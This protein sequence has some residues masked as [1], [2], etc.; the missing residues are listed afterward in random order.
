MDEEQQLDCALDLMRRLPPHAT[1]ASLNALL[2]LL[3]HL[4]D[5]L[6]SHIDKPLQ[7]ST[8]PKTQKPYLQCAYNHYNNEGVDSYRSPWCNEFFP[9]VEVESAMPSAKLRKL[10]I[11]ANEAFD[12]YRDLYY[13]GGVSSVYMWDLEDGFACVILIKKSTTTTTETKSTNSGSWDSIHVFGVSEK[14]RMA[15][16]NLTSTIM[17]NM[18]TENS[19]LGGLNL[20]GSLTRQA[21]QDL[22]LEDYSSHVSNLGRM[23]EDMELKLRNSLQV[24]YFGKTS[25]I[26][27]DLRSLKSLGEV[28]KQAALQEELAGELGKLKKR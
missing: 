12:V 20:S 13:E 26:S 23:V 8:C 2:R 5:E 22:P 25:D 19:T 18:D 10:E 16:Y 21:E 27:N 7:L 17:L 1:T 28:K 4:S 3:P 6:L 14:S 11:S 9:P 24:V 15:K